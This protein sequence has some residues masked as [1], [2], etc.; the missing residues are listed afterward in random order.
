MGGGWVFFAIFIGIALISAISHVLK[1]QQQAEAPRRRQK[2]QRREQESVRVSSD[3]DQDRFLAEIER[4]RRK[5]GAPKPV[6]TVKPVKKP[7]RPAYVPKLEELPAA[8]VATSPPPP[9]KAAFGPIVTPASTTE[10]IRTI[11]NITLVSKPAAAGSTTA[12]KMASTGTTM[13]GTTIAAT[14][15]SRNLL[16]L[17]QSKD[18][19]PMAVVLTE[20]LGPPKSMKR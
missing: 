16:A 6:P 7:Q 3:A 17:L 18:A 2:Q 1:N 5:A 15:F 14:R 9:P 11:A 10:T 20:I 12:A 4:L 13:G 19:L 8:V